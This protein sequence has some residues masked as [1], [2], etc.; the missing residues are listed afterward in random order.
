MNGQQLFFHSTMLRTIVHNQQQGQQ[1]YYIVQ[2]QM[3]CVITQLL[4]Q[5]CLG[6]QM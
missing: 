5:L 4:T 3:I 2:A 1:Q 6:V